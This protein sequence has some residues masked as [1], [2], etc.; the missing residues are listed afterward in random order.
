MHREPG[1]AGGDRTHDPGIMSKQP[2]NAV[3][4][5]PRRG[6]ARSLLS[7]VGCRP[8]LSDH[9]CLPAGLLNVMWSIG[10]PHRTHKF[11][12]CWRGA[13]TDHSN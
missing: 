6:K 8:L 12:G 2:A 3:G 10:V 7:A 5:R 9:A 11:T 1:R 4:V 13:I